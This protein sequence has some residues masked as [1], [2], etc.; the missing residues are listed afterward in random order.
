VSFYGAQLRT[1]A[2]VSA[3]ACVIAALAVGA[4]CPGHSEAGM[5]FVLYGIG[6]ALAGL[7]AAAPGRG[8]SS[9]QGVRGTG[10]ALLVAAL[11]VVAHT[12]VFGIFCAR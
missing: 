10:I 4:S 9:W 11:A 5:T 3:A 12:A 8:A 2:Y 6:P 1:F 7:G